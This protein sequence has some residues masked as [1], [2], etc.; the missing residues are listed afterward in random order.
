[1]KRILFL[2]LLTVA[3]FCHEHYADAQTF[4]DVQNHWAKGYIGQLSD[5]AVICGYPDGTFRPEDNITRA[6]FVKA[7]VV[8]H[9]FPLKASVNSTF[10]DVNPGRWY[11]PYIETAVAAGVII[12]GEYIQLAFEPDDPITRVE[13]AMFLSR[14]LGLA[15]ESAY[16]GFDDGNQIPEEFRG[17][18]R[19]AKERDLI[20]GYPDGTFRPWNPITRAEASTILVRYIYEQGKGKGLVT[21]CYDHQLS[22]VYE[23]AFPVHKAYG[24]PGVNYVCTSS[25]GAEGA[26]TVKQLKEMESAG[27]ETASHSANH[28]HFKDLEE[29]E[30]RDQLARSKSWLQQQ[31]LTGE[32]FA[33]PFR[34]AGAP[35]P[36]VQEYYNSGATSYD[37]E[38]NV[39]PFNPYKLCRYYLQNPG[40]EEIKEV[41]DKTVAA[42]GWVIFYTHNVYE[43]GQTPDSKSINQDTLK[44]LF[45]ET[46]KR[47]IQVATVKEG[48]RLMAGK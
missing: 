39:S 3:F 23:N 10:T 41:L 4:Y 46:A 12:P 22:S 16:T 28:L 31:G 32:N 47:N 19:T 26:M 45:E 21:V 44:L 48:L 29:N 6:E 35:N 36:L 33:Y 8:S 18:I 42:G 40:A 5:A 24:Y 14:S 2:F 27:W 25:V 34:F 9:G 7:L 15:A 17:Y 1:M 43:G 11:Y 38:I 37:K 13:A 20:A 30:I